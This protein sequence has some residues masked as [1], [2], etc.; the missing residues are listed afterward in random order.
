MFKGLGNLGDMMKKAQEA[1]E[2]MRKMDED[3]KNKTVLGVSGAG[4]VEIKMNGKHEC[5]EVHLSDEALAEDK[6]MLEAL[7][8]AAFND[9]QRK[10]RDLA[11]EEMKKA[12]GFDL[13]SGFKLPF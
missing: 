1:Q 8:T 7:L 11:K 3:L 12:V 2:Q 4:A 9:A 10:V 6:E 13:P 5:L